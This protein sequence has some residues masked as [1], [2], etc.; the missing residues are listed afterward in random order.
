LLLS[1]EKT[2]AR[3]I[4]EIMLAKKMEQNLRKE[5]IMYL[6]LNQIYLGQ[7]AHGV[8]AAAQVYFRKDVK[9]LTIPEAA[10]LAGLPQAPSRY[11]PIHN[12]SAAKERQKYVINRMA[13][14]G[15][16]TD[17]QAER[18]I[19][20]P[21]KLYVWQNFKEMAPFYLETVRQLLVAEIG[22]ENVLDKG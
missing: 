18:Y 19:N 9:D 7:G 15:Y 12:P 14:V 1:S 11:S 22:E 13:D 21:V 3:K 4:K 6:Y 2:Y 16:I 8:G 5:D 10:I 20:E 17:E